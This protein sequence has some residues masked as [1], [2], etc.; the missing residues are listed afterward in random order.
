MSA[1]DRPFLAVARAA[2][3]PV[4]PPPIIARS[5][6]T[7]SFSGSKLIFSFELYCQR[8]FCFIDSRKW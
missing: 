8:F 2:E 7:E 4:Y 6:T 1:T 5:E 3:Q